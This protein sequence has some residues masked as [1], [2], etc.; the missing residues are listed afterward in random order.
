MNSPSFDAIQDFLS[1]VE[2]AAPDLGRLARALDQLALVMHDTPEG[3]MSD[4]DQEPPRRDY[5]KVHGELAVRFPTLGLY[6]LADA[7]EPAGDPLTADAIDDLADIAND[8]SEILWRRAHLGD[9]DA[10]WWL[11]ESFRNHWGDHLRG[12]SGY[13]HA[14]RFKSVG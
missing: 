6:G 3:V 10:Y 12:L 8:L 2:C 5:A 4:S 13:L 1:E 14:L 7:L 9:D 11:A